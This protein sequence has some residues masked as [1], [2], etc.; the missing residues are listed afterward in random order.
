MR[1]TAAWFLWPTILV[2]IVLLYGCA[3]VTKPA[4]LDVKFRFVCTPD[5]S[6]LVGAFINDDE[7]PY[8]ALIGK[9]IG[10]LKLV[11]PPKGPQTPTK[12]MKV[13]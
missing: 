6:L 5:D 13:S 1:L 12:L 10:D 7:E 11:L 3:T 4:H 9:C 8:A 2:G